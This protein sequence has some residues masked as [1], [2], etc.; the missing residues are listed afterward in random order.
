MLTVTV[1]KELSLKV[2]EPS[3]MVSAPLHS[4][5]ETEIVDTAGQNE[6]PLLDVCA[7]RVLVHPREACSRI[8]SLL[9]WKEPIEVLWASYQ[10]EIQP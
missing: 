5:R 4:D 8:V 9:C 10:D 6:L 3:P 2:P 7:H 1:R